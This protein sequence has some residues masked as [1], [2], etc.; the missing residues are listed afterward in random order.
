MSKVRADEH[1]PATRPREVADG[2][3]AFAQ[4]DGSWWIN[5]AGFVVGADHVMLVDTCATERR[6]RG[7]LDAVRAVAEPPI[8]TVVNTHGHGDHAYGNALVSDAA[9]VGHR[10]CR[11]MLLRDATREM[12]GLIWSPVPDWGEVPVVAPNLTFDDVL[13]VHVGD[14]PVELRY[15]GGPAHTTGDVVAW[16]PQERVLFTGD[17]VMNGGTPMAVM[18]SVAGSVDAVGWVRAFGAETL[19]P[20]HG[21]PC[22]PQVLD[23]V[24]DYLQF[25]Q[26][27]AADGFAA[28][29]APLD[30]ARHAD[31]GP[32]AE[33]TDPERLVLNLHR[34]YAELG[35]APVDVPSAFADAVAF[36]GG[37]PLRCLA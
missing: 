10:E 24:E 7:L 26:Q 20:G 17:L 29:L 35:G 3:Y 22:G 33:L 2:V 32:W 13:T 18:G 34:A 28:G 5:T 14:R 30:A 1:L 15:V 23:V 27:V 9:I 6:T 21:Q 37:R 19:V 11:Q 31:L 25:V 36:N 12:A 4:A 16:L 8:R